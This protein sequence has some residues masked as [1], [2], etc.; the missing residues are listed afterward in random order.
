MF[1]LVI[2]IDV[3]FI[4]RKISINLIITQLLMN[5]IAQLA[6]LYVE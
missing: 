2:T 4:S 6:K 1:F 5:C 3:T